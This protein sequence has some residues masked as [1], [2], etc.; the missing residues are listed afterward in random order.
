[1][2]S[3]FEKKIF[4]IEIEGY[5]AAASGGSKADN[6]YR[7]TELACAPLSNSGNKQAFYF[8]Q[9]WKKG[10]NSFQ[11]QRQNSLELQQVHAK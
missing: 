9:A 2:Q 10:F 5:T 6:P 1:M 3:N 11:L 8:Y 4:T 7:P